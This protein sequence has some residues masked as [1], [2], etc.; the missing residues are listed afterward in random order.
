VSLSKRDKPLDQTLYE[1]AARRRLDHTKRKEE[2]DKARETP[3]E[4]YYHNDNSDKYV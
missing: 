3:K 4:T 2:L 1:D